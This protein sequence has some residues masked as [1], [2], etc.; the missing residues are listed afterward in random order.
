MA[1]FLRALTLIIIITLLATACSSGREASGDYNDSPGAPADDGVGEDFSGG[2]IRHVI[3]EAYLTVSVSNIDKAAETLT[4]KADSLGGYVSESE[5]DQSNNT[6]SARVTYRIPQA[7]YQYFLAFAREQGEPGRE[8]V[9]STDVTEDFV[10]LEARLANRLVHE[11]RLLEMISET[12]SVQ[13]LLSVEYE[14]ARVREDIEVIQGRLRYL[15]ERT[16]M[17]KVEVYLTQAPG[18]T[19]IPGLR[20]MGIRET[21]RRSLKALVSSATL[22]LDV[23]SFIFIALA[24]VLP[25]ALPILLLIWLIL[26]LRR[27]N[28]TKSQGA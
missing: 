24:A 1:R 6:P 17:S 8:S 7:K 15:T 25:F 9:N 4:R 11:E 12:A 3:Y 18:E 27:K 20:P 21:L 13:E 2:T 16:S 5:K 10:D 26:W 19:E 14:L 23:I 22:F 28:K